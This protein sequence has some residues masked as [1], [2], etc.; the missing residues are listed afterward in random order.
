MTLQSDRDIQSS[1]E[2]SQMYTEYPQHPN[3]LFKRAEINNMCVTLSAPGARG[4][5]AL[6]DLRLRH[7]FLFLFNRE[8]IVKYCLRLQQSCFHFHADL[9]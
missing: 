5:G 3:L 2:L 9:I 4:I 1:I 8:E 7:S 6:S